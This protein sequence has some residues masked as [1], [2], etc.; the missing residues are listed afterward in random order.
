MNK[1]GVK[2]SDF[3]CGNVHANKVIQNILEQ[4]EVGGDAIMG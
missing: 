2:Q 3:L 1:I 4:N